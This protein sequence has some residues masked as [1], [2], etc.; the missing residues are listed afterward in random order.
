[1]IDYAGNKISYTGCSSCAFARREFSLPSGMIYED[2]V[3]TLAQD[4]TLPIDGF[5]V[6]AP[7]RHVL[8][9]QELSGQERNH[10][11]AVLDKA[12][13][14]L[15]R[16][17]P[18]IT[19]NVVFE[20]EDAGEENSHFHIWLMPRHKWMFDI[21]NGNPTRHIKAVF[22]Y[23]RANLKTKEN[24]EK[25]NKTCLLVRELMH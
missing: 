15:K 5:L 17:I 2:D 11:F 9:L 18:G 16:A 1:M 10:V 7:K 22:D 13:I 3:L 6:I 21:A 8:S 23:A 4:W 25:I 19:Y 24:I 20:E 12:I 14:A